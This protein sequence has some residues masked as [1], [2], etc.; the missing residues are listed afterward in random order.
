M[1]IP[2]FSI[3]KTQIIEIKKE[4]ERVASQINQQPNIEQKLQQSTP[5]FQGWPN[6][7]SHKISRQ[8]KA[9]LESTKLGTKHYKVTNSPYPSPHKSY[10]AAMEVNP[11]DKNCKKTPE[12]HI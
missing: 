12:L 2:N 3:Q 9:P 1:K 7:S 6:F 5:K 11:I 8:Q 10:L 4:K